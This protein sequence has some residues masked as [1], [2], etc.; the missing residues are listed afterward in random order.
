[1]KNFK[2]KPTALRGKILLRGWGIL[3][4]V[5]LSVRLSKL[6]DPL[7]KAMFNAMVMMYEFS[8]HLAMLHAKYLSS[9]CC[10]FTLED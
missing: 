10:C 6:G 3:R 7:G 2:F 9:L 4:H 8:V 5:N 1:M